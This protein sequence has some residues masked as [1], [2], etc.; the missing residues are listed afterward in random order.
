MYA[1]LAAVDKARENGLLQEEEYTDAR[2]KILRGDPEHVAQWSGI[3]VQPDNT[4][5]EVV[6]KLQGSVD[7]LMGM[8]VKDSSLTRRNVTHPV[9]KRAKVV[10]R[11]GQL[12]VPP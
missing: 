9:A 5:D 3:V 4:V 6:Q 7:E 11:D 12:L 10:A 1:G 8:M 2:R